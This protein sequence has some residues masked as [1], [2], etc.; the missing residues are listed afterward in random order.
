[1][2]RVFGSKA[3]RLGSR[4]FAAMPAPQT[5]PEVLYT[6]VSRRIRLIIYLP[7]EYYGE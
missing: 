2:L 4:G 1:M 5:T 3:V 7:V 6:G